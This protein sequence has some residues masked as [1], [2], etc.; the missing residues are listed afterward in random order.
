MSRYLIFLLILFISSCAPK[1]EIVVRYRNFYEFNGFLKLKTLT[2]KIFKNNISF[3][4]KNVLYTKNRKFSFYSLIYSYNNYLRIFTYATFGKKIADILIKKNQIFFVLGRDK[5]LY[6]YK[7]DFSK[8]V[9]FNS[10]FLFLKDVVKGIK[11]DNA[12][13]KN[14]CF[15]G[16][17]KN[18]ICKTCKNSDFSSL[19]LYNSI[20]KRKIIARDKEILLNLGEKKLRIVVKEY[21]KPK[22]EPEKS[23]FQ[24]VKNYRKFYIKNLIDFERIILME[25]RDESKKD[26]KTD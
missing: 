26:N 10:I 14:G 20:I 9:Y 25:K 12:Y 24:N 16:F 13:F 1:K 19:L 23:F 6:I 7:G 22:I 15:F 21:F 3:K 5:N 8:S 17:Y 11:I 4:T 2:F 18:L